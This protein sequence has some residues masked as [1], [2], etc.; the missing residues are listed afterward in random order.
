MIRNKYWMRIAAV[1]AV[2]AG[3]VIVGCYKQN[4]DP[5]NPTGSPAT[6][7]S[8]SGQPSNSSGNNMPGD[9][10][11]GKVGPGNNMPGNSSGG[12]NMPGNHMPGNGP[13]GN[14][15]PGNHMPGN[16]TGSNDMSGGRMGGG[17]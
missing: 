3:S 10:M 17:K 15:M 14:N 6:V 7:G 5:N 9:N 1:T 13:G 11:R 2:L 4:S 16:G 8:G 12:N